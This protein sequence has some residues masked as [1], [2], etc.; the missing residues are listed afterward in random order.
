VPAL[1]IAVFIFAPLLG[2]LLDR[3][4]LRRL[5]RAPVYA[6]IV[7]TIGLLVALP[8]LANWLVEAVGNGLIGLG[9]PTN[10]SDHGNI[11]PPGIGPSPSKTIHLSDHL[12]LTTDQ[13]AVLI[14][15]VLAA[16]VLWVVLRRTRIGLE[17]RA[18][19]DREELAQ[20]RGINAARS[21]AVA[22]ILT[23]ILAGLGGVLIAPLF[24]LDENTIT[25]IALGSLAAVALARLR[26]IPVALVG[27]LLL[28]VL[29]NLVAGYS[30]SVL[31]DFLANLSGLRTSV[32]YVITLLL[33]MF[34]VASRKRGRQAGTAADDVPRPDHRVGLPAW[35]RRLPWA[36]AT[37]AGSTCPHSKPT[38]MS[39]A[40][41]CSA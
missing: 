15:A 14:C 29:A 25:F 33:L 2:L 38:A 10:K 28:G 34:W 1:I 24:S 30:S 21:S 7:G 5:A 16:I 40:S 12:G 20:L 31:P 9:L 39:R 35:R 19:V 36:I 13:L 18:V 8:N 4:V 22:W 27:G 41:S 32:P 17:M 26:S 3:V 37:L 11:Q 6:R 23:M